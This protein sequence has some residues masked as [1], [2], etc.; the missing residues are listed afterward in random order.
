MRRTIVKRTWSR[1]RV[2][3]DA[4]VLGCVERRLKGWRELFGK[5]MGFSMSIPVIIPGGVKDLVH[6]NHPRDTEHI[7]EKI[8]LMVKHYPN[9]KLVVMA[10]D[11]CLDCDQCN[12]PAYYEDMLLKAGKLLQKRFPGQERFLVFVEF[13]GGINLVEA[14]EE[15]YA[16]V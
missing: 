9:L 11:E 12:D 2:E 16:A 10:H 3:V 13:D 14:D 7:V 6:P 1:D 5:Y 15:I 4:L 8:A